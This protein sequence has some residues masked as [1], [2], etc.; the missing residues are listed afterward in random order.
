[1]EFDALI[2]DLDGTLLDTLDDLADATNAMLHSNGFPTHPVDS[3]NHF[4]G[5]GIAN[6]VRRALPATPQAPSLERCLRMLQEEYGRRWHCKTMPY[7]GIDELLVALTDRELRLAVLSNKPHEFT[8]LVIEH[9][10]SPS[11]FSVVLGATD[12]RPRKPDPA[13]VSVI[14]DRLDVAPGRTMLVG[15]TKTDM[16]T[17]KEA[18]IWAVGVL[19][20]F[21][22]EQELRAHGADAVIDR[23]GDLLHLIS[24]D[25]S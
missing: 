20:G 10:F 7:P 16:I 19:W 13:G 17:A 22:D 3:Y 2:F 12:D 25:Q 15:D 23:P 24:G 4:V 11:P 8:D 21:R 14:L 9:F 6:L 18:G 1:M 5:D